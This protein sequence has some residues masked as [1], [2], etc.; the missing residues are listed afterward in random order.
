MGKRLGQNAGIRYSEAFKMAVV[1]EVEEE[2]LSFEHG[3]RKYGILSA[4][5][6]PKWV[7]KY[8]NGSRG[9]RI[10]VEKPEEIDEKKRLRQRVRL[11]ERSLADSNIELALERQYTRLACERAGIKDVAGFKKKAGGKQPTGP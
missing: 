4:A 9:K 7:R 8:G 11:L 2:D 10:R 6:V 3:R 5:T 1:R